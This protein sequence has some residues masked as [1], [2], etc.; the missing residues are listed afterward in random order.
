MLHRRPGL[1][2]AVED[3][4]N[5]L[6]AV[7]RSPTGIDYLLWPIAR[8]PVTRAIPV[9]Q[10][11]NVTLDSTGVW[12]AT[13]TDVPDSTGSLLSLGRSTSVRPVISGVESYAWH[14]SA[15]GILGFLKQEGGT[16]GAYEATVFPVPELRFELGPSNPGTLAAF[17]SWGFALQRPGGI[18]V[19]GEDGG[20][21]ISGT[22]LDTHD[23]DFLVYDTGRIGVV[24]LAASDTVGVLEQSG[25]VAGAFSPDGSKLAILDS[26]GVTVVDRDGALVA[27]RMSLSPQSPQLVWAGERFLIVPSSPRG[28]RILD[29]ET[30]ES[31]LHLTDYTVYRVG[32][33]PL[34]SSS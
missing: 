1:G 29:L 7:V 28:V 10:G 3:F 19:I 31:T 32:V 33:I 24:D 22:L 25:V 13:M 11:E 20:R 21:T 2:E 15:P 17:G 9:A 6:V 27:S 16:W 14:E 26:G 4:E 23:G 18:D 12:I 34:A 8:A 30:G 5:A